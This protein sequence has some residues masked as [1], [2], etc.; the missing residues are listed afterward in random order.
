MIFALVFSRDRALQLRGTLDSLRF[1]VTDAA[2][3]RVV[4][5]YRATSDRHSSQYSRLGAA[6]LDTAALVS[7]VDF[8]RQTVDILEGFMPKSPGIGETPA[9]ETSTSCLLFLVD[10]CLFVRSFLLGVAAD[11]LQANPD[12][13]GYSLRLG[14][15]TTYSYSL[16]RKQAPPKFAVLDHGVR[17][18][19]WPGAQGDFG[20]PLEISSSMYRL[21]MVRDLL[22]DLRFDSPSSLESQMALHAQDFSRRQPALLCCERSVAFC[23]PLNRVQ[24]LFDN[25]TGI[26]AGFSVEHLADLYDQ[27]MRINVRKLS[28]FIP[29]ACHQEVDLEFERSHDLQ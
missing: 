26:A 8:R 4:V 6:L 1:Q 5:L 20:Y 14:Q 19:R 13:I 12:A 7:E 28:G 17:K 22:G 10:D 9:Q 25:R 3:L 16:S 18:F 27:G 21:D 11:A 29:N 23:T 15:N 24:N 2:A